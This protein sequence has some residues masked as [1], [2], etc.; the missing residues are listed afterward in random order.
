[1][2]N[3]PAG[4][5]IGTIS[6]LVLIVAINLARLTSLRSAKLFRPLPEGGEIG[7]KRL[8]APDGGLGA[9]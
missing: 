3:D 8:E 6:R 1:M 2:L 4:N 5:K 9:S 7:A